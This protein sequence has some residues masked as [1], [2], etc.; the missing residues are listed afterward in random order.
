MQT[1]INL[2]GATFALPNAKWDL[3]WIR[4]RGRTS[5]CLLEIRMA[6]GCL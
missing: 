3:L 4:F 1:V 6:V 2:Y 5:R